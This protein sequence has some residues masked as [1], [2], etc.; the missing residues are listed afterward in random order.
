V[1]ASDPDRRFLCQVLA[2][3]EDHWSQMFTAA[4]ATYAPPRLVFYPGRTRTECGSGVAEMGPFYCPADQRIYLD[5]SFFDELARRHGAPGDFAQAY[6]IGH[7]VGHHVQTLTGTAD[8]IRRAQSGASARESNAL[9]VR[10]ELQADCYAGVWAARERNA[11]MEPGDLEEGMTAAAAIGDDALQRAGQGY[12]Q[13]ESFTHGSSA[14]RQQALM[15]GYQG[16]DPSACD[17]YTTG[18]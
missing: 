7:E 11:A 13:P 10:M 15:R 2:S 1:C 9:Q 8:A 3:T 5:T 17:A 18:L 12:V 16:G 4:G 6:V 14:Q